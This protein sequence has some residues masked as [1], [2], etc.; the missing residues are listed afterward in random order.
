LSDRAENHAGMQ[1]IGNMAEKGFTLEEL[2]DCKARFENEKVKCELIN[3]NDYAPEH[4][5]DPA[6][7]L[8]IRNGINHLLKDIKKNAND[9]FKELTS[10]EWD[11]KALMYGRVVNKGARYNI[12]LADKPQKADYAKGKGTIVEFKKV[13]CTN[14]IREKISEYL[15]NADE[16]V[17]EGNYY[18]NKTCG[19]GWH[20]D[21]ERRKVIGLKI[22]DVP[23]LLYHWYLN[24]K[25]IGKTCKIKLNHGDIYVMSDKTVGFDWKKRS[26]PTLRHSTG[27]K[28]YTTL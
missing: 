18:Y 12:C 3:L 10:L 1:I 19:I 27:G 6:Y 5:T 24:G 4:K 11:T 22:G 16:L 21:A 7:V 23:E 17:G 13:E 9:M 15:D 26:F 8:V 20:G 14:Y 2:N 28:K 25:P